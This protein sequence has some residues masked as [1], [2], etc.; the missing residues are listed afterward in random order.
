MLVGMC[1]PLLQSCLDLRTESP[2]MIYIASP[3]EIQGALYN[4][5]IS[6]EKIA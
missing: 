6:V 3:L 2:L 5:A 4:I 1:I